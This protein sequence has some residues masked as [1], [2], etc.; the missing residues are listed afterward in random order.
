MRS[1]TYHIADKGL[2]DFMR[3]DP[4]VPTADNDCHTLVPGLK[5]GQEIQPPPGRPVLKLLFT[6]NIRCPG[7][8][9]NVAYTSLYARCKCSFYLPYVSLALYQMQ[10]GFKH[11]NED[12]LLNYFN[13]AITRSDFNGP[14]RNAVDVYLS[15][16]EH[17]F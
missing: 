17:Q 9:G 8:T 12:Y 3:E 6:T 14:L 13:S 15:L 4:A 11:T 1:T 5:S 16:V 7:R 2:S 10:H